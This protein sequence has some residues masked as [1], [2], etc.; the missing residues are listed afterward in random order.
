M[1]KSDLS[2]SI[3]GGDIE[4]SDLRIRNDVFSKLKM[5]LELVYGRIGYLR[6]QVPWRSL[7]SKPVI[8]DIQDVWI[9]VRKCE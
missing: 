5:P 7:G 2:V 1:N 6:I 4:L 3:W 9:V 8:V